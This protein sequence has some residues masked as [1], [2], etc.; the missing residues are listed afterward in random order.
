MQPP[1]EGRGQR[2]SATGRGMIFGSGLLSL[3]PTSGLGE[4][5]T[6]DEIGDTL[7]GGLP[8]RCPGPHL[9]LPDP[10]RLR[11]QISNQGFPT[12]GNHPQPSTKA[13]G[14]APSAAGGG[15]SDKQ[16]FPGAWRR[17]A[18]RGPGVRGG[19]A[20]RRGAGS[21]VNLGYGLCG[22]R[23]AGPAGTAGRG[24]GRGRCGAPPTLPRPRTLT[25]PAPPDGPRPPPQLHGAGARAL[26]RKASQPLRAGARAEGGRARL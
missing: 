15:A 21:K 20:R 9:S 6:H 17:R 1:G 19:P 26:D 7:G 4:K 24:A 11:P 12:V 13:R 22:S 10:H 5:R 18:R 3:F 14:C 8:R 16:V 25:R 2:G 23:Q